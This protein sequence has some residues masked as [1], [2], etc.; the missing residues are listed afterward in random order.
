MNIHVYGA[1]NCHGYHIV[2]KHWNYEIVRE[3]RLHTNLLT[4]WHNALVGISPRT[5]RPITTNRHFCRR[6]EWP[7]G[8]PKKST[9]NYNARH[10]LV[11]F[12]IPNL[13]LW[14]NF[15]LLSQ[16]QGCAQRPAICRI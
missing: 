14:Q 7:L 16:Q 12:H 8:W 15:R 4:D 9:C 2:Y 1:Y 3:T 13:Q 6:S 5:T 11:C 10:P